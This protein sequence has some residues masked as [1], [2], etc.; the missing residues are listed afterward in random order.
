MMGLNRFPKVQVLRGELKRSEIRSGIR[1]QLTTEEFVLQRSQ[2]T[3]RIALKHILGLVECSELELRGHQSLHP[4]LTAQAQGHPYKI[5]TT[6]LY[7]VSP[8]GVLEQSGVSLYTRLS[9]PF[10]RQMN[11]LLQYRH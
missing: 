3:Y 4:G 9:A 5:V 7:M 1:Y 8:S 10:A 11:H 6:L 2:R